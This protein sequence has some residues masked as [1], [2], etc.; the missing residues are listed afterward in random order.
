MSD[1]LEGHTRLHIR[2]TGRVQGVGFRAFVSQ[3]AQMLGLKGWVRNVGYSQVEALAEGPRP[4]LARF[5]E[6]VQRG[7]TAA[8][9][10][11]SILDW[12]P[13]TGEFTAFEVRR[14]L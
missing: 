11:E 12:Y 1:Q 2:V 10:D 6:I 14:S 7:P 5:V 3:Q 8:R 9:V 4:A 13:P